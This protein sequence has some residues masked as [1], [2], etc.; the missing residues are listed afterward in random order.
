MEFDTP[1]TRFRLPPLTLQPIV[2]NAVKYGINPEAAPLLIRV[3][4]RE[5]AEG[6]EITVT[7]NGP[8][9]DERDFLRPD[10]REPHMALNN[11]RERLTMMCSG[12]L[13]VERREEGGSAVTIRIPGR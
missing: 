6:F 9:F 4:S 13:S 8:G 3:V 7:D 11:I 10:D 12:T 2:E 1:A 5:T